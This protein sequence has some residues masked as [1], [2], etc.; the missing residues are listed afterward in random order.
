M[1]ASM[2]PSGDTLASS[3]RILAASATS[4]LRIDSTLGRTSSPVVN[5]VI[6]WASVTGHLEGH[7]KVCHW[8]GPFSR[9]RWA[10]LWPSRIQI[11][12]PSA[13][14]LGK[15]SDWAGVNL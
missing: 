12:T 10:S 7:M 5:S 3:N 1:T 9:E 2:A 15:T 14:N 6:S 13:A 11:P 8:A 4:S